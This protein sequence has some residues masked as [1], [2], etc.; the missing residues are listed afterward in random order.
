MYNNTSL[1]PPLIEVP[2]PS[3]E[4]DQSCIDGV[5]ILPLP[6]IFLLDFV[7]VPT[8]W[9]FCNSTDSVVFFTT[10]WYF[11]LIHFIVISN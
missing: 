10:V 3:Q 9:Y 8:V 1:K 6:T 5:S 4:R 7:T 11:F 2:V